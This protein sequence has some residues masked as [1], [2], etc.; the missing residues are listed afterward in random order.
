M[1][2]KVLFILFVLAGLLIALALPA[3]VA[4]DEPFRVAAVSPS[5]TNDL[6]FSQSMF[7]AL[8]LIQEEMGEDAFEFTF[9]EGQFNVDDAAA[10]IRDWA[11][12]G[13]Y[14][15]IIA[16]GSQYGAAL[17]EI[18]PEF[19]EIAFAWGTDVNTFGLDNVSA[20]EAA[21]QEG[22]YINGFVAGGL[23]QT[24]VI[25]V[26]GPIEVGDAKLY[27]DGFKAGVAAFAEEEGKEI[28]V[29]VNYI[30]SFSDV[31]L[32]AEAA[33]T[34]ISND[35]D[36]LSG[37]AQMVV[38]AIG[39]A[40]ERGDVY[41]FGTQSSQTEFGGEI[42]V[43]NQIYHW[44]VVLNEI[45]A[46]IGEG[47]LGGE[48]YKITLENGGL[49]M[50]INPDFVGFESEEDFEALQEAVQLLIDGIVAGEIEVLPEEAE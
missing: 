15:L 6:A 40:Q 2:R 38:G 45:I 23:T 36:I 7:D 19:P 28:T 33:E 46:N 13:E 39:V 3:A 14:D 42:V 34:H 4:Q 10:T 31:A 24:D 44:E 41:W 47:K 12:S 26:I 29:N 43:M 11:A 21:S 22:G 32:A 37:T 9:I 8:T 18:A 17:E 5:A 1:N 20:Y 35:A 16:H 27:V 48:S 50:E 25:G 49:E 30:Q